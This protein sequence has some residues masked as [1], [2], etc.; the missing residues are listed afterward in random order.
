LNNEIPLDIFG[1]A[2]TF[3]H[4]SLIFFFCT[5]AA[6]FFFLFWSCGKLDM[7]EDPKYEMLRRKDHE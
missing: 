5:A 1:D 4:Y 6:I 3:V 2:G 7:D